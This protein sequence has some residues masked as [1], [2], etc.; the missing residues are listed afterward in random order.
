[1]TWGAF[2]A[3]GGTLRAIDDRLAAP[4]AVA[5]RPRRGRDVDVVAATPWPTQGGQLILEAA[6]FNGDSRPDL[7]VGDNSDTSLLLNTSG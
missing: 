1:M 7:V 3:V 4:M 5:G 6:D 2:L